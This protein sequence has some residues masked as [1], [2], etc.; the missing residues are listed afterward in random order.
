MAALAHGRKLARQAGGD[1]LLAAPSQPVLRVLAG[2]RL[3]DAFRA[4]R[5][6]EPRMSITA[7]ILL[8]PGAAQLSRRRAYL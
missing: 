6:K 5:C 2:I 8:G 4:H 3:L 7:W 1:M